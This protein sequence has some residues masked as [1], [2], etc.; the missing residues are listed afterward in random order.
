MPQRVTFQPQRPTSMLNGRPLMPITGITLCSDMSRYAL[1]TIS[2][3]TL[4][5]V[6]LIFPRSN[7]N[8]R[9]HMLTH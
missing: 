4:S 6:I 5:T 9:A 1:G 8:V 2:I 7:F 3:T